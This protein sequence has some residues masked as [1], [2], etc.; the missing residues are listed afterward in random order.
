MKVKVIEVRDISPIP[1]P[2]PPNPPKGDFSDTQSQP[3][4]HSCVAQR[5]QE[6]VFYF[7]VFDL[8]FF[9]QIKTSLITSFQFPPF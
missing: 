1:K 6:S 4:H 9:I 5:K 7:K 2:K 3:L 8:L